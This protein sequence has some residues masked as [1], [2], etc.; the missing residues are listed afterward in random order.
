MDISTR[1]TQFPA[2]VESVK[3]LRRIQRACGGYFRRSERPGREVHHLPS[4]SDD[5]KNEWGYTTIFS[6][7]LMGSRGTLF[8]L[9]RPVFSAGPA[10]RS[11]YSDSLRAGR[12]G[13]KIPV[14]M[15]FSAP[16]E[17]GPR[18]HPASC[19]MGFGFLSQR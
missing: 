8:T 12:P 7:T 6:H 16:V 10:Q 14:E 5:V 17:T 19:T 18:A 2:G 3:Y 4:N 1:L 15:K 9:L 11:R 13:D